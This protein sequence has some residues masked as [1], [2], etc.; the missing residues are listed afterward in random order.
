MEDYVEENFNSKFDWSDNSA[1]S[2]TRSVLRTVNSLAE[3]ILEL[4]EIFHS[5]SQE[6][7]VISVKADK[8]FS[9][10]EKTQNKAAEYLNSSKQTFK[11]VDNLKNEFKLVYNKDNKV[12]KD[13][14]ESDLSKIDRA[15][16]NIDIIKIKS[17]LINDEFKSIKQ[18]L[19]KINE[20]SEKSDFLKRL[21]KE[22][23]KSKQEKKR[24]KK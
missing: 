13:R 11:L 6:L 4:S 12:L 21:I 16:K 22:N 5:K 3:H 2:E 7:N 18:Y 20:L 8:N 19:N 10:A 23:V 15:S 24:G 1:M 9:N 14:C 17:D